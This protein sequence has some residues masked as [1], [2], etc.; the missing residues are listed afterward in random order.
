V[1]APP[2]DLPEAVLVSALGR[3]WGMTVASVEYRADIA[4]DLSR[5]RRP[6]SGSVN[7]DKCWAVLNA[8]VKRVSG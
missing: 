2:D 1:L 4:L 7:D 5:F 6:H 3:W 8:L